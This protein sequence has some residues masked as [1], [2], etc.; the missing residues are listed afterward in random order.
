MYGCRQESLRA[1]EEELTRLKREEVESVSALASM[2]ERQGQGEHA[3]GK[4]QVRPT[5]GPINSKEPYYQQRAI[6]RGAR[7][8]QTAG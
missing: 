8:R 1:A 2:Q 7:A 4:L 3:L 5:K 6:L